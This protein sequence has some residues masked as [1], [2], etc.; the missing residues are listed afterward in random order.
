MVPSMRRCRRRSTTSRSTAACTTLAGTR[1]VG[2]A[3]SV[4]SRWGHSV[5][6]RTSARNTGPGMPSA[7]NLSDDERQIFARYMEIF[8][9]MVDNIDQNLGRLRTHLEAMGEWDNTIIV[10]TSDNGGSRR[11]GTRHVGVLSHPRQSDPPEQP[12][13]GGSRPS[14]SR[15]QGYRPVAALSDGVGDGVEHAVPALQDQHAPGR[16]SGA[17]HRPLAGR[18]GRR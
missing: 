16:A 8:A 9:G 4:N 1:S 17:L 7:D 18:L 10:F 12:R 3:T 15:C 13:L 5:S 2:S 11:S 6:H 14:E